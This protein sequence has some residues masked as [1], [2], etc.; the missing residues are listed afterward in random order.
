[1][2]QTHRA[3]ARWQFLRFAEKSRCF[4]K[5]LRNRPLIRWVAYFGPR[6]KYAPFSPNSD[7]SRE[8]RV[9]G[10]T[11]RSGALGGVSEIRRAPRDVL[12]NIC[13]WP[14]ARG[15]IFR[16]P[17]AADSPPPEESRQIQKIRVNGANPLRG[18]PG[19][20]SEIRR[21]LSRFRA[22]GHGSGGRISPHHHDRPAPRKPRSRIIPTDPQ[23]S[24]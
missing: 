9:N 3:G 22:I 7:R 8:I 15:R 10:A 2:A 19:G 21:G 5:I 23:K 6:N 1:M 17:R 12:E 24:E 18:P 11:P 16:H 4:L 20:V 13:D 14:R